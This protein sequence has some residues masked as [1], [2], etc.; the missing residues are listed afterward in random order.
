MSTF[1]KFSLCS[2]PFVSLEGLQ[3]I[4]F[5]LIYLNEFVVDTLKR[6]FQVFYL[7]KMFV[8]SFGFPG[9]PLPIQIPNSIRKLSDKRAGLQRG[10]SRP[11]RNRFRNTRYHFRRQIYCFMGLLKNYK[12][13]IIGISFNFTLFQ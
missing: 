4:P 11:A 7:F 12:N 13:I 6:Q 3:Q 9:G 1:W 2:F 5:W 8:S 10:S